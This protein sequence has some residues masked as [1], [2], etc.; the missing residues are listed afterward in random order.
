MLKVK[1]VKPIIEFKKLKFSL[2]TFSI[3]MKIFVFIFSYSTFWRRLVSEFRGDAGRLF[4]SKL[5][6][7]GTGYIFEF[8]YFVTS[9]KFPSFLILFPVQFLHDL[10]AYQQVVT[11]SYSRDFS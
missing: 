1:N 8:R 3:L 5:F 9:W 11:Q 10:S 2:S 4:F 7:V 6:Y